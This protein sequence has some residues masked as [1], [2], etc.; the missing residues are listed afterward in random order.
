MQKDYQ[1]VPATLIGDILYIEAEKSKFL[2][3]Y[4]YYLLEYWD[5]KKVCF[6]NSSSIYHKD[7]LKSKQDWKEVPKY[8]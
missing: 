4:V 2:P 3:A 1:K 6:K 8:K 7:D 5:R